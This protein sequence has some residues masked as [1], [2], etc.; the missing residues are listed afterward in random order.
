MTELAT[1]PAKQNAFETLF[2]KSPI[3]PHFCSSFL[4]KRFHFSDSRWY[5]K[6]SVITS[7]NISP[8]SC[9]RIAS[10]NFPRTKFSSDCSVFSGLPAGNPVES[11][12]TRSFDGCHHNEQ[13]AKYHSNRTYRILTFPVQPP[14]AWLRKLGEVVRLALPRRGV[15]RPLVTSP[16]LRALNRTE[17]ENEGR[18]TKNTMP[19]PATFSSVQGVPPKA[20]HLISSSVMMVCRI[21][22]ICNSNGVKK[23]TRCKEHHFL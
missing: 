13:P 18:N 11:P 20:G 14:A 15:A 3:S 19:L 23:R 9:R 16:G 7:E 1:I 2:F 17:E 4:T 5:L 10:I 12:S 22:F 8:A 21:Y 6:N